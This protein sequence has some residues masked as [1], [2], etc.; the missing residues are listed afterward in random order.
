MAHGPVEVKDMVRMCGKVVKGMVYLS[1]ARVNY[2]AFQQLCYLDFLNFLGKEV[3]DHYYT[4]PQY[5][6]HQA[7]SFD[8]TVHYKKCM[9][10]LDTLGN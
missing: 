5:I 3:L 1:N 2:Y 4:L 10:K 9:S 8:C 7:L 6:S